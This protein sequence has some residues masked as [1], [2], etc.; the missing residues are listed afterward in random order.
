MFYNALSLS[1]CRSVCLSVCL[2]VSLSLLHLRMPHSCLV[3][4]VYRFKLTKKLKF[5]MENIRTVLL[6]IIKLTSSGFPSSYLLLRS[7]FLISSEVNWPQMIQNNMLL[8]VY[9]FYMVPHFFIYFDLF[10]M[11]KYKKVGKNRINLCWVNSQLC[12]DLSHVSFV[13]SN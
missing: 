7:S 12:E 5:N 3:L 11:Y 10:K 13:V 8:L 4:C 2:S 6:S 1:V 9:P